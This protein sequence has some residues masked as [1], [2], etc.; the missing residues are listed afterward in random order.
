MFGGGFGGASRTSKLSTFASPSAAGLSSST[1]VAKAFGAPA[2]EEEDEEN[3]DEEGDEEKDGAV[4]SPRNEED[5]KRDG[6]FY[7][8]DGM[9][10]GSP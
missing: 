1:K 3:E 9:Y 8:Q 10:S 4:K 6:R 7:A 5:E 2:D